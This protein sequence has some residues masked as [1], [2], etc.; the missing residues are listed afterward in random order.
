MFTDD[1]CARF[2]ASELSKNLR[3]LAIKAFR[4]LDVRG[5]RLRPP[6]AL[7]ASV[8][9]NVAH[10]YLPNGLRAGRLQSSSLTH[11]DGAGPP[12]ARNS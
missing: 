9:S 3:A 12:S 2:F 10:E 4:E 1:D 7:D 11:V 8:F 5:D 6:I